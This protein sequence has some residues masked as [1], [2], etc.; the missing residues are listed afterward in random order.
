[1]KKIQYSICLFLVLLTASLS[2]MILR[3][4]QKIANLGEKINLESMIPNQFG[5]WHH[6][7]E[8]ASPIISPDVKQ[9]LDRIYSQTLSRTYVN[10]K[11][12]HIMLSIAYGEDQSDSKQIHYPEVC[13]PAQGFQ[14]LASRQ[15]K[16]ATEFGQIR[17][18]HL[19]A[20][21]GLR[22]EPVTYWTTIG[23]RVVIGA[24]E[25]KF[26]Q[27]RYGFNGQIPD[28]LLFRVSSISNDM[29]SAYALH[30]AFVKTLLANLSAPQRHRLAGL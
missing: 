21:F 29:V 27:L 18:K 20:E 5:D 9:K 7:V 28:G 26:E 8:Q 25:S 22:S 12:E 14:I 6:E 30:A 11:G 4:T 23:N 10:E 13:Y 3:P 2:A 24:R 15:A 17:V 1:M 16:L 19:Y